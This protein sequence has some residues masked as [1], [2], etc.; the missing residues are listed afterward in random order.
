V[1]ANAIGRSAKTVREYLEKHYSEEVAASRR[2]TEKLAVKALLEVVQSGS[3]S[4][5][6]AVMPKNGPLTVSR[7]LS[8]SAL[9]RHVPLKCGHGARSATRALAAPPFAPTP[10]DL[11]HSSTT[12]IR[13][14]PA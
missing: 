13:T 8:P 9:C 12:H 1:Q 7:A 3:K 10:V 6:L 2:E 14:I 4:I 11:P 5:E